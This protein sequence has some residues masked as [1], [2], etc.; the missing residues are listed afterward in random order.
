MDGHRQ[1]QQRRLPPVK[2]ASFS[3]K[4]DWVTWISQFEAIAKR[5]DCRIGHSTR[6]TSRS[7]PHRMSDESIRQRHWT[8]MSSS[9]NNM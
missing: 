5:T 4:E 6:G 9:G 1:N 8:L 7:T 3:G 2:M